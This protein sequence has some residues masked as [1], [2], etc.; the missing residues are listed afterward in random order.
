MLTE[1]RTDVQLKLAGFAVRLRDS[2]QV[3]TICPPFVLRCEWSE[4]QV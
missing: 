2:V 4:L 3:A 1:W